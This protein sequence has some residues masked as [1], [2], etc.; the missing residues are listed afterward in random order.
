[1]YVFQPAAAQVMQNESSVNSASVINKHS[2]AFLPPNTGILQKGNLILSYMTSL[3]PTQNKET[4][5]K[6][7]LNSLLTSFQ[8][9]DSIESNAIIIANIT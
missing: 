4:R 1:M 3:K 7:D 5:L 2:V 8:E 6:E 9:I